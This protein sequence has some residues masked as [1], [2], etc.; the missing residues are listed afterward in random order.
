MTLALEILGGIAA[1]VTIALGGR[2]VYRSLRA[3]WVREHA[4]SVSLS[5]LTKA[6]DGLTRRMGSVEKALDTLA[7][8]PDSK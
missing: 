5:R 7:Q 8:A 3:S 6:V 1:V 2:S 4:L